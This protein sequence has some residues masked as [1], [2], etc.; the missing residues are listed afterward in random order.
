MHR[1]RYTLGYRESQFQKDKTF[2]SV[3]VARARDLHGIKT[4]IENYFAGGFCSCTL[5]AATLF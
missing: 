3:F 2:R 4:E 5:A 1:K